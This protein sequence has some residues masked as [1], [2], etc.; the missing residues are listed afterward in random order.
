MTFDASKSAIVHG[1]QAFYYELLRQ[2]ERALS[3]YF[4]PVQE[5]TETEQAN[6]ATE[7]TLEPEKEKNNVE[8]GVVEIQKK[9]L[10]IIEN[11]SNTV[12]AKSK[13]NPKFIGDAKYIMAALT[14]E[15]FLNLRWEGAKYWR[16]T[17]LEK[18]LFQTELAGDKFFS[19]CDEIVVD[20]SNEEMAFV[21]LM[22]LSLGFKGR[23]RD[24]EN[25]DEQIGWYKDR[26]HSMLNTKSARLFFPGRTHMIDSCYEY[27]CIENDNSHL[28][29]ARFWS[30]CVISVV[31]L[32]IIVS[33]FVWIG[34]TGEISDVLQKI[35]AQ[36]R[37][38][39]LI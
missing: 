16:Y 39:A 5:A 37:Q 17:L 18:Q 10:A 14:D 30:W 33:Y 29:D 24:V 13:L 27:T 9:L 35:S 6:T 8:G 7:P 23:Y 32:Y 34:I 4:A 38:G 25:A 28:P 20:F 22:T 1:F 36:T 19:M 11:V 12:L 3:L 26:L 31:F 21:Y 15:I 2:K